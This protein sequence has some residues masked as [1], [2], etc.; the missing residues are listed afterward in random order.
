MLNDLFKLVME[1]SSY[2]PINNKLHDKIVKSQVWHRS[3]ITLTKPPSSRNTA[4]KILLYLFKSVL[5]LSLHH[6]YTELILQNLNWHLFNNHT[7]TEFHRCL[8]KMAVNS[9]EST[10][11]RTQKDFTTWVSEGTVRWQN[12]RSQQNCSR[13]HR[14]SFLFSFHSIIQVT[15]HLFKKSH[16]NM[17]NLKILL[18]STSKFFTSLIVTTNKLARAV[19]SVDSSQLTFLPSSKSH[20][21]KTRINIKNLARL[22]RRR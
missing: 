15:F 3:Y 22:W 17:F 7:L 21:T 13:K 8:N 19:L 18:I 2:L 16:F 9:D 10:W 20:D 6:F 14:H 11:C 12:I 4:L 5:R 1:I